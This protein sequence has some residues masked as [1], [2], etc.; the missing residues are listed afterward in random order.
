MATQP[1]T[2][3]MRILDAAKIPY[4]AH[5]YDTSDGHIDGVSVAHKTGQD[6]DCVF[7]TLV[8]T[9][10]VGDYLVFVIPVESEL[11]L[12]HAAQ[13]AGKKAV[14]MIAVKQLL[15]VTGYQRGGCSPIGLKKPYPIFVDETAILYD[16]II[17]SGGKIG[18]QVELSV[19]DLCKITSAQIVS[20]TI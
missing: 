18:T 6:P 4:Q 9:A 19:E 13:V 3:V 10:G 20:L 11:P 2:N 5:F 7:K 17:V 16:R 14:E 12:K 15:A 1:K 8:A